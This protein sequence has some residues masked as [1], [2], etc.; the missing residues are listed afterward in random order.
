LLSADAKSGSGQLLTEGS[1]ELVKFTLTRKHTLKHVGKDVHFGKLPTGQR[2]RF[3]FYQ[4]ASGSFSRVTFISDDF[5]HLAA[6]HTTCRILLVQ[7]G[8]LHVAWQLPE[9]KDYNGD[10]Q[11]PPDIGQSI[12]RVNEQT[13]VWRGQ[14]SLKLSELGPGVSLRINQTADLPGKPACCTDLWIT[15]DDGVVK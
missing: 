1:G 4:D 8:A 15:T 2:Y 6:N 14:T 13:R 5:S 7:P 11:R 10:M 9:V 12:L 3:H